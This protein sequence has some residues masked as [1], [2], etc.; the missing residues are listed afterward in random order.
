MMSI[1]CSAGKAPPDCY[2][3]GDALPARPACD[4]MLQSTSM[5][6]LNVFSSPEISLHSSSFTHRDLLLVPRA[7]WSEVPKDSS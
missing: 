4:S 1:K 2:S 5:A 6:E 3:V 7:E